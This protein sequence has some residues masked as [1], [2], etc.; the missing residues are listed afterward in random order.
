M[1]PEE[2]QRR[3]AKYRLAQTD[4]ALLRLCRLCVAIKM[5]AQNMTVDDATN[6]LNLL[7]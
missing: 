6:T 2:S 5:H 1:S 3:A 4:E 7:H